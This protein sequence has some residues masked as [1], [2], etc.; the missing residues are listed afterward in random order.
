MADKS[1]RTR[2]FSSLGWVFS[3]MLATNVIAFVR[4][5]VLW[6]FIGASE[7]G[8]NATVWLVIQSLAL[9]QDMGFGQA[10]IQ[11]RSDVEK[12]TAVTWWANL[13]IYSAIYAALFALA[14]VAAWHFEQ[15]R[16]EAL[17][18]VA[19]LGVLVRAFGGTSFVLLRREFKFQ[20]VLVV[21]TTEVL[22]STAVQIGLVAAGFGVWGLVYGHLVGVV[23]RS[24]FSVVARPIRL[25]WPDR[26]VAGEMFHFGKHVTLSSL[27]L[28]L[29]KN[30]D[31]YFVAKYLG[32]G[33]L[34]FY[35]LAYRVSHLISGRVTQLFGAVLFPAFAE[36]GDDCERARRAWLA[37]TRYCM[38]V[39]TPLG[40]GLMLFVP[41]LIRGFYPAECAI[42]IAPTIVLT[43]FSM[44]RA[45]GITLGDLA[46]G[47]GRP[48]IVSRAAFWH[49]VVM[50][51]TL[52]L[53]VRAMDVG[54]WLVDRLMDPSA[55]GGLLLSLL[56]GSVQAELS[57]F[58]VS[59]AVAATGLFA[60]SY[61]F[62]QCVRAG[63]LEAGDGWEALR[64]AVC[65]GAVMT[66]AGLVAKYFAYGSLENPFL[67]LFLASVPTALAYLAT[68]RVA[69]PGVV[70]ELWRMVAARRA[71]KLPSTD[72]SEATEKVTQGVVDE[73]S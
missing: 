13:L 59:L 12:A 42:A 30:V 17:I 15:P 73:T 27:L 29:V 6:R 37:A 23:V 54:S 47:M 32:M 22:V 20:R 4:T 11:R 57:L 56:A 5:V 51:P 44:C 35:T 60:I 28:W 50:L 63:A 26:K 14:P 71:S 25:R 7:F 49:V 58:V 52:F 72:E 36:I 1:L 31:N 70:E 61:T 53:A 65:A 9:L 41:E 40:L 10:L 46:R 2:I 3:N 64:P 62:M 24:I 55:Y 33:A 19:G 16:L 8:L 34:G 21:N 66:V 38:L 45:L 39:V 69:F 67:V 43:G 18:R 68:L 48:E